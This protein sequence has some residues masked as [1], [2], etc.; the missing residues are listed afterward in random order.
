M[1]LKSKQCQQP[2]CLNVQIHS[3][4]VMRSLC[5]LIYFKPPRHDWEA[6]N[7]EKASC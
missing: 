1:L 7:I 3:A 4:H 6:R 5:L 2:A